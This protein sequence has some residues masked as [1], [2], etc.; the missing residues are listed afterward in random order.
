MNNT[1]RPR[2]CPRVTG[3]ECADT[4]CKLDCLSEMLRSLGRNGVAHRSVVTLILRTVS[5]LP[6]HFTDISFLAIVIRP[7]SSRTFAACLWHENPHPR[8]EAFFICIKE[9]LIHN[10]SSSLRVHFRPPLPLRQSPKTL[11]AFTRYH[12]LLLNTRLN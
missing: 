9:R 4:H 2:L 11:P 3:I 12:P 5:L 6:F 7:T 8:A 1:C 10:I